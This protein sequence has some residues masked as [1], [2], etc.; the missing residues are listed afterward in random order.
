MCEIFGLG[1]V[2]SCGGDGGDA[3]CGCC[4]VGRLFCCSFVGFVFVALWEL[5]VCL[6]SAVSKKRVM[7]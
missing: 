1:L 7:L 6:R 3:F 2:W 5:L 4:F